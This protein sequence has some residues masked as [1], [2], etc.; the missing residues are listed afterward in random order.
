MRALR[1]WLLLPLLARNPRQIERLARRGF[2][3]RLEEGW[4]LLRGVGHAFFGGFNAMLRAGRLAEVAAAGSK[5]PAH[6]RPFFFEGAAMGYLPRGYLGAQ[7][8][9]ETAERDLLGLDP[10]FRYLYYVGLG[11]WFGF[12]YRGRPGSLHRIAPHV[13]PLY[14]PLCYDGLGFKLGFFDFPRRPSVA[15]RLEKARAEHRD[16]LYQGFGRALYFV[17]LHDEERFGRLREAVPAAHRPDLEVGRS[18]ALGFTG[19]DRPP[20]LSRH[21]RAARDDDD[22]GSRLLGITWALTARDEADPEYLERCLERAPAATRDFLAELPAIC[23][24]SRVHSASYA[25]WQARTRASVRARYAVR[26]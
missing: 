16:A 22:L 6:F 24:E 2:S 21:L 14:L 10:G 20:L 17:T 8:G 11:F 9:I 13:D 26:S 25:E 15:R 19:V 3:I 7:A 12:R 4:S 1:R 18:L 23:R 5:V